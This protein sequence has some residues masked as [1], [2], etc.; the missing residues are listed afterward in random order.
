MSTAAEE[1]VPATDPLVASSRRGVY[2]RSPVT[3]SL[4]VLLG[5][6]A[7]PVAAGR[8]LLVRGGFHNLVRRRG[9]RLSC[10]HVHA[11]NRINVQM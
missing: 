6:A 9:P 8:D 11:K 5:L 1:A 7:F 3:L 2:K 4:A 10:A